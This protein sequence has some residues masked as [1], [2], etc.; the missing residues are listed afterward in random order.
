M[1]SDNTGFS[2]FD[3][4]YGRSVSEPEDVST[5]DEIS[6]L[7]D[8]NDFVPSLPQSTVSDSGTSSL[9]L[10]NPSL[11]WDE[12]IALED[13]IF[14]FPGVFS[15]I[16]VAHASRKLM[17]RERRYSAIEQEAL[18]IVF[19]VTKFDFYLR[20]KE[21]ILETDHKPLVYLQTSKCS[22]D[23]LMRSALRPVYCSIK[24]T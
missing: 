24:C 14:I 19:G 8:P 17:D 3:L 20:G 1:P 11:T 9:P 10:I 16:P 4:L 22:N 18:A 5:P 12:R 21:F 13:L 2:A 15:K 23:R 6:E 7:T